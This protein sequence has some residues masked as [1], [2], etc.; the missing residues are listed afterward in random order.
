VTLDLA[1]GGMLTNLLT[2]RFGVS[3]AENASHSFPAPFGVGGTGLEPVTS[4]L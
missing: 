1:N 3:G 2:T 4:C